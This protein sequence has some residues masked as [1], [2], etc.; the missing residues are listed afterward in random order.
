MAEKSFPYAG[1]GGVTDAR[2]EALMAGV[3]GNGRVA[4]NPNSTTL[5]Q[6]LVYA[7][8]TGRQ[9][10][11]RGGQAALIRGFRWETDSEGLLQPIEANTSGQP[12]LDL[13][14]LR[15]NRETYTVSF[16]I[17][18]GLPAATPV[19]PAV[20]QQTGT[21]GVWE[22]PVATIRVT[23]STTSGLPSIGATDVTVIDNFLASPPMT[24]HSS[25]RPPAAWG[26]LWTEYDTGK[27]FIGRGGAW[28]LIGENGAS[29]RIWGPVHWNAASTFMYAQRRN[30]WVEFH[31]LLLLY[32]G[33]KKAAGSD[34]TICTLPDQFR[35]IADRTLLAY[36]AGANLA[37][38]YLDAS[39]GR[40]A[41]SNYAVAL[42]SGDSIAIPPASWI[43]AN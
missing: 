43:A 1:G 6:G 26:G 28:H 21:T 7:D 17:V 29:T 4:Y 10:K 23:S 27:T 9:I 39:A 36:I 42:E 38:C 25:R 2:Y 16:R 40:I 24:G 19:A 8:S 41:L 18:K 20:S 12:R 37:R 11:V 32:A 30:G 3:T 22:L 35:P 31:G 13:A 15:L 34:V 14:V 5:S 33:G